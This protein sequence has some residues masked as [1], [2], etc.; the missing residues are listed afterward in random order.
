MQVIFWISVLIYII[1]LIGY[2]VYKKIKKRIYMDRNTLYFSGLHIGI[3][4]KHY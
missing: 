3:S 1:W 4:G 2:P